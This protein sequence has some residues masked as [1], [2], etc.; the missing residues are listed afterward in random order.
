MKEEPECSIVHSVWHSLGFC[1]FCAEQ[2]VCVC[3]C[4]C[5]FPSFFKC[6]FSRTLIRMQ[7]HNHLIISL[8]IVHAPTFIFTF[9]SL[10]A[11]EFILVLFCYFQAMIVSEWQYD[12]IVR[13]FWFLRECPFLLLW[14]T[15]S[16]ILRTFCVR[17]SPWVCKMPA[18]YDVYSLV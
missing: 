16:F 1:V 12:F 3:M 17:Y 7:T 11:L 14:L 6:S 2:C 15:V 13:C 4:V 8:F 18:T 5:V 10:C 9:F